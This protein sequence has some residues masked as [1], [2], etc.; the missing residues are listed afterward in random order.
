MTETDYCPRLNTCEES[1]QQFCYGN[2]YKE[3]RFYE[4]NNTIVKMR[5][6]NVKGLIKKLE[7]K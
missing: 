6:E 1:R 5:Q 2:S 3:C 7:R 4:A